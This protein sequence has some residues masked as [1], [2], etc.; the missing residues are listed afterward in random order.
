[1]REHAV[2]E[3]VARGCTNRQIAA[4]LTLS[5]RT[6]EWHVANILGKLGLDSRSQVAAWAAMQRLGAST[7]AGQPARTE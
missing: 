4:E 1:M 6:V 7:S 2:M 5:E 3:S